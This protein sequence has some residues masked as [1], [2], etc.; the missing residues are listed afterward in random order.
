[1]LAAAQARGAPT[2]DIIAT[3][4]DEDGEEEDRARPDGAMQLYLKAVHARLQRE[5][6]SKGFAFDDKWLL[7]ELRKKES[8]WWL[9]APKAQWVCSKLGI[10]FDEG[11]YYRDIYIWLPDLQFDEMPPCPVCES[12]TRAGRHCW[13]GNHFGR[14]ICGLDSHYF[15]ISLL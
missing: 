7:R 1:M 3:L 13:R 2:R 14:R 11:S 12:N 15:T 9:P 6:P 5:T 8:N 10:L 4:D